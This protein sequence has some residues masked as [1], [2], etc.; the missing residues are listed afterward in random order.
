MSKAETKIEPNWFY[1][2][3]R[4]IENLEGQQKVYL[5]DSIPYKAR[6]F[7]VQRLQ[8]LLHEVKQGITR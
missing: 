1:I 4:E 7:M 3:R 8:T 6:G 2:I 5:K